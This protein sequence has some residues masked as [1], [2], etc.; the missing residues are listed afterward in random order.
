MKRFPSLWLLL[1][2]VAS[3]SAAEPKA[4]PTAPKPA[5]SPATV[6]F[7][8]GASPI[9]SFRPP[10]GWVVSV[11][12]D[13]RAR[14]SVAKPRGPGVIFSSDDRT[15]TDAEMAEM[16]T[17]IAR[18][19]VDVSPERGYQPGPVK[20]AA[21]GAF[22]GFVVESPGRV[23][24][25]PIVQRVHVLRSPKGKCFDIILTGPPDP[26]PAEIRAFLDSLVALP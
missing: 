13:G 21:L 22:K 11:P 6:A 1:G 12:P 24:N 25:I 7:P 9:L 10:E 14:M 23:G 16:A 17:S 26:L 3:L 4:S 19:S 5:A 18:L 8:W 15:M 2:L 20:P